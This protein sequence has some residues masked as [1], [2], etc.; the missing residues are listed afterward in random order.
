MRDKKA[1]RETD[2]ETARILTEDEWK[3]D[4]PSL[5]EREAS[6]RQIVAA[7]LPAPR[8]MW[9]AVPELVR[10]LGIRNL[11]FGVEDCVFLAVL[12]SVLVSAGVLSFAASRPSMLAVLL[13]IFSPLFYM[14]LHLLTVWK[15]VMAHTYELLMACRCSLRQ[16]TAVRML[17]FGGMSLCF[18]MALSGCLSWWQSDGPGL[19]RLC[20]ISFASLFLFACLSLAAERKWPAPVSCLPVPAAWVLL[21]VSLL[22]LGER[23][24]ALLGGIFTMAFALAGGGGAALYFLMLKHYYFTLREGAIAYAVR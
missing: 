3:V 23:A 10:T 18:S 15:E 2:R 22:L 13:F 8:R 6:I 24:E 17:I 19:L 4:F 20:S 11:F 5:Q 16:L 21:G 1:V 12:L 7:G 9:K 14:A